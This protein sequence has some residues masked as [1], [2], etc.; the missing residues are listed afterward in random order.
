V[1]KPTKKKKKAVDGVLGGEEKKGG[2]RW[3]ERKTK[4]TKEKRSW[5]ERRTAREVR[6][7][8]NEWS[9]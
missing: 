7:K 2:D 3:G 4:T 1:Q 5:H 8:R 6:G 9:A